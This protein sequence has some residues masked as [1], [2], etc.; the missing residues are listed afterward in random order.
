[1]KKTGGTFSV[2][3]DLFNVSLSPTGDF[4]KSRYISFRYYKARVTIESE[5]E[6]D[7]EAA[8]K[9]FCAQISSAALV[10]YDRT[11]HIDSLNKYEK[12]LETLERRSIYEKPF[13]IFL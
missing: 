3:L 12:L 7:T 8:R 2:N 9:M 13:E 10:R 5:D 6:K 1:M 4:Y 11:P